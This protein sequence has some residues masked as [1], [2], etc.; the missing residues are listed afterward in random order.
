MGST[1]ESS[2]MLTPGDA[3]LGAGPKCQGR[4]GSLSRTCS[5][6]CRDLQIIMPFLGQPHPQMHVHTHAPTP[7][8]LQ[9]RQK[10]PTPHDPRGPAPASCLT[11]CH[12]Q[13]PSINSSALIPPDSRAALS[14]R[15]RQ[16][17]PSQ[18]TAGQIQAGKSLASPTL[19]QNSYF[20]KKT[21][22]NAKQRAKRALARREGTLSWASSCTQPRH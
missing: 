2:C 1:S 9:P 5:M 20:L 18:W 3:R 6:P 12:L 16:A 8:L 14:A 19:L 4:R 22:L 13:K 7:A 21:F 17:C 10:E 11:G 15:L